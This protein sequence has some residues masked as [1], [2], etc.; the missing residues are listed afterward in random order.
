MVVCPAF[1]VFSGACQIWGW[2]RI[3]NLGSLFIEITLLSVPDPLLLRLVL[4]AKREPQL[5]DSLWIKTVVYV[6]LF[7]SLF[8]LLSWQTYGSWLTILFTAVGFWLKNPTGYLLIQLFKIL[9][10]FL[11]R[12]TDFNQKNVWNVVKRHSNH[13]VSVQYLK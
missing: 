9:L 3:S 13:S 6:P 1:K 8:P 4:Q 10:T 2:N 5:A 7:L 12:L 11:W